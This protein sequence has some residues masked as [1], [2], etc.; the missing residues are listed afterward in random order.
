MCPSGKDERQASSPSFFNGDEASAVRGYIRDLK[1][2]RSLRLTDAMIGVISPYNAQCQKIRSVI[3]NQHPGVKVGSVEEFQG[4]ERRA[5]IIS[6]VRSS[7]DYVSYDLRHTLG[8]VSNARRFNVAITRAQALV[9]IVGDPDVLGLD[10]L[11]RRFL[12]YIHNSGG[13]K[14]RKIGWDPHEAVDRG[15]Y[16]AETG[17]VDSAYGAHRRRDAE[18]EM[19]DLVGRVKALVLSQVPALEDDEEDETGV[20]QMEATA[21]RP[22]REVE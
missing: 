5:I 4:Q 6:T 13:W 20:E 14:G 7:M 1:E 17:D 2:H 15:V 8:F 9:V 16:D 22:W 19:D 3:K 21:D 12:N 10:P 18:T 11:W